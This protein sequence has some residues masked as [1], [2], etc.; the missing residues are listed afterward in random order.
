MRFQRTRHGHGR[1]RSITTT[2]VILF[3]GSV[4]VLALMRSERAFLAGS[5]RRSKA[6]ELKAADAIHLSAAKQA[7]SP[8]GPVMPALKRAEKPR[9]LEHAKPAAQEAKAPATPEAQKKQ[10]KPPQTQ[11]K[12][13]SSPQEQSR[14]KQQPEAKKEEPKR[15][16]A[17]RNEG[18]PVEPA[19]TAPKDTA[20]HVEPIGDGEKAPVSGPQ[21]TEERPPHIQR[22]TPVADGHWLLD[23]YMTSPRR[24]HACLID[25]ARP[26]QN[27]NERLL[28]VGGRFSENV[29]VG[30]WP[31]R[32]TS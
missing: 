13:G 12:P 23:R 28:L 20:V 6:L 1:G 17:A 16:A 26:E 30:G 29:E 10:D 25:P 5:G 24:N 9:E 31:S 2:G 3:I 27:L 21:R 32:L 18:A 7:M 14:P 15:E 22:S 11:Q 8:T 4:V 19:K